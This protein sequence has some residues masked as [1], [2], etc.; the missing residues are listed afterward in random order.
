MIWS[1]DMMAFVECCVGTWGKIAKNLRDPV[2][3]GLR[4][5]PRRATFGQGLRT[6]ARR[7]IHSD[8]SRTQQR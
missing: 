6:P 2:R 3:R 7:V 1:S 5:G 8:P 4:V